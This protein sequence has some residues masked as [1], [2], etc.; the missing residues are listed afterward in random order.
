V[1]AALLA[2][3]HRRLLVRLAGGGAACTH[4]CVQAHGL[5]AGYKG[6]KHVRRVQHKLDVFDATCSLAH[7]LERDLW[8][9]QQA[10]TIRAGSWRHVKASAANSLVGQSHDR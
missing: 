6:G 5:G 4:N 9:V 2:L 10:W 7:R 3:L 8:G 1:Q